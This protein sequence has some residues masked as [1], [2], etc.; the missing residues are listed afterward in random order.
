MGTEL[1]TRDR[2]FNRVTALRIAIE[3]LRL[4]SLHLKKFKHYAKAAGLFSHGI[5][6]RHLDR[7]ADSAGA[8]NEAVEQMHAE[9]WQGF[10]N[11]KE[12]SKLIT[13]SVKA[14]FKKQ[15]ALHAQTD[16]SEANI[17]A[18]L[19]LMHGT[20]GAIIERTIADVFDRLCTYGKGENKLHVNT[21]KTNGAYKIN[22]KLIVP[23][24]H[25][26]ATG[27]WYSYSYEHL[28]DLEK[29]LCFITGDNF[30]SIKSLS[31]ML[32]DFTCYGTHRDDKS[33]PLYGTHHD[34]KFFTAKFYKKGTAHFTFKDDYVWAQFNQIAAKGKNWIGCD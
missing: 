5:E 1:A 6:Q 2:V 17:L 25:G 32:H 14:D 26:A 9:A 24:Q 27:Q 19:E 30:G 31:S 15:G 21:W 11:D 3:E 20:R 12:F 29:A 28:D 8:F 16:F 7:S 10:F 18:F 22:K 34:T 4:A 33:L 23:V 13:S